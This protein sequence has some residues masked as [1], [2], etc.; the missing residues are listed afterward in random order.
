ML[1]RTA[2]SLLLALSP[3]AAFADDCAFRA[4]R[5]L[6]IDV[7]GVDT[8]KLDTGAVHLFDLATGGR[9]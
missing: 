4:E 7:K 2:V 6:D 9:I 1:S 5:T 3:L 8:F